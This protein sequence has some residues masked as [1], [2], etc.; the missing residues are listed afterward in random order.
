MAGF[1]L[2]VGFP[3]LIQRQHFADMDVD[4]P[5]VVDADK[6]GKAFFAARAGQLPYAECLGPNT[7]DHRYNSAEVLD[8]VHGCLQGEVIPAAGMQ[9]GVHSSGSDGAYAG[10]KPIPVAE[11]DGAQTLEMIVIGLA[12]RADHP[13]GAPGQRELHG[14]G[15]QPPAAPWISTVSPG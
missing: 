14:K 10:G 7:G 11:R 3:G 4:F 5:F 13:A 2:P 9:G 8:Q 6:L 15:A 12:G 1:D